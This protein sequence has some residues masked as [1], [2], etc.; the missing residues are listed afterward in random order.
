[1]ADVPSDA[2]LDATPAKA[3]K[4]FGAISS[5][6]AIRAIMTLRGYSPLI[7]DRA[8]S[9]ILSASG[10]RRP[11]AQV[12]SRPEAAAAIAEIDKWDEPNFRVARAA[13]AEWPEQLEYV[14]A[15]LEAQ[16]GVAAVASVATFLDRTDGLGSNNKER[17]G[18]RKADQA[19][20][21]KL[22][23]RGITPAV[24]TRLR[25]LLTIATALPE[26]ELSAGSQ[27]ETDAAKDAAA[28]A[29]QRAGKIALR[30]LYVEWS[31]IAK[32]DVKRRDYLILL[33]LATRKARQAAK[34]KGKK[35]KSEEAAEEVGAGA[36]K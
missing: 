9:L 14:F 13:L 27:S 23:E 22:A 10:F 4:M 3:L 8:W 25:G 30:A 2:T 1:M 11:V 7:H 16:T 28:A 35:G 36:D 29:E 5:H 20:L 26:A 33:G 34:K 31:E 12:L 32:A 21:D 6:T 17:K 15:D 24:R 18:T 19:A